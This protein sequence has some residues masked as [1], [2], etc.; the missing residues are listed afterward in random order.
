MLLGTSYAK[1]SWVSWMLSLDSDTSLLLLFH[2]FYSIYLPL[3]S[4]RF[5]FICTFHLFLLLLSFI[6]RKSLSLHV[7]NLNS[8]PERLR[9]HLK[10]VQ[11]VPLLRLRLRFCENSE[12]SG[13][14]ENELPLLG[15][16][17]S[18]CTSPREF[19]NPLLGRL[20]C[21]FCGHLDFDISP[22]LE[23]ELTFPF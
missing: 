3:C 17:D 19:L 7:E 11:L 18:F 14:R 22:P 4:T 23:R 13:F 16:L 5:D 10:D 15:D 21:R 1:P 6:L 12:H 2:F 8:I 20:I 9:F